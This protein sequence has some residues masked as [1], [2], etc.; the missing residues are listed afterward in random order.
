MAVVQA[1]V[2]TRARATTAVR[3]IGSTGKPLHRL[4]RTKAGR[5]RRPTAAP[6]YRPLGPLPNT[7]DDNDNDIKNGKQR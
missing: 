1:C 2:N 7:D 5:S 4:P 3:L 6:E